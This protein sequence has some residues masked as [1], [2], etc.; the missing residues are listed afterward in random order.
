MKQVMERGKKM[1]A[2][3][4]ALSETYANKDFQVR[5]KG[6]M[7]AIDVRDGAL[8]KAIAARCF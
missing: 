4:D 2:A 6:M 5:G 7:Q 3:L 8:A 1:R